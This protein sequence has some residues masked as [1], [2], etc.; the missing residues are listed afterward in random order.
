MIQDI[1]GDDFPF[2]PQL[3]VAFEK[4]MQIYP[5]LLKGGGQKIEQLLA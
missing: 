4:L 3:R 5:H 2:T 1:Q